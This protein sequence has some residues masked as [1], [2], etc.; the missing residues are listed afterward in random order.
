MR[1]GGSASSANRRARS[2]I[3]STASSE[4]TSP[5]SE[6]AT[7]HSPSRPSSCTAWR[8]SRS[9]RRPTSIQCTGVSRS[10]HRRG[11]SVASAE[12]RPQVLVEMTS[13]PA[14]RYSRCTRRT[15]SGLSISA[16]VPHSGSSSAPLA[17][18]GAAAA[19]CRRRRRGSRSAARRSTARRGHRRPK[20]AVTR[21]RPPCS[22]PSAAN[23]SG[24]RRYAPA[25]PP[26]A[27]A[28]PRRPSTGRG[29]GP[30][31][32]APARRRPR[33][34]R[35]AASR[36]R[37]PASRRTSAGA[38]ANQLSRTPPTG[39]S[40]SS[41]ASSSSRAAR[42]PTSVRAVALSER[43][44]QSTAAPV[45]TAWR[46][47]PAQRAAA[48]HGPMTIARSGAT[49]QHQLRAVRTA[50]PAAGAPAAQRLLEE[51]R[52][53]RLGAGDLE[54]IEVR[55]D[56]EAD[57]LDADRELGGGRAEVGGDGVALALRS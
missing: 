48:L 44:V 15:A 26:G 56:R 25:R 53:P 20:A 18:A 3:V 33:S 50:S 52:Q 35:R 47:M 4:S 37:S 16:R 54:R 49:R 8:A 22:R 38:P 43:S 12:A 19:R 46:T 39:R 42:G 57:A 51:V 34:R 36:K 11:P 21:R 1:S 17:P 7:A 24:L 2:L 10:G 32:R 31:R 41:P 27:R 45:T 28:P 9:P 6:K 55:A 29:R 13:Q 40:G 30:R 5:L 14:C 23:L